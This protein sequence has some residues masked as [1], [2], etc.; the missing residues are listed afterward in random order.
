MA[1]RPRF[2]PAGVPP[3][4]RMMKARLDDVPIL[5]HEEGL[6]AFEYEAVFWGANPQIKREEAQKLGASAKK[7]DVVLSMH[8]SY[9]INLC[10][11][12]PVVDASTKRLIGCATAASW[13]GAYVL[14]F[15]PGSYGH[16]GRRRA[17]KACNENMNNVVESLRDMGISSVKIGPETSGKISQFGSLDEILTVCSEVDQTQ[18]VID[19]SHVHARDRGRLRAVADFREVVQAVESKLGTERVRNMHCHFTKIE[20]TFRGERRHHAL[21]E[22][23]YGPDF[24]GLAQII[25]EFK[26]RPVMISESPL[27]DMDALKMREILKNTV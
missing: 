16:F 11:D 15:H 24:A 22:P 20:F 10:G 9:F 5:L 3:A 27:L 18:L 21:D 19:W 12:K 13:M 26:L 7:S 8:G 17:L 23:G 2:G 4:F 1:D 14:V 6:D 25:K